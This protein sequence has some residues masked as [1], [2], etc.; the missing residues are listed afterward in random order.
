MTAPS[1]RRVKDCD[2][3]WTG[4]VIGANGDV[5]P[6]CHALQRMGNIGEE[7]LE[8]IWDGPRFR[9]FRTFL[10]SETPLPVCA[11]CF[12]RPW[13]T[14]QASVRSVAR[15]AKSWLARVTGAGRGE[16]RLRCWV[17][18]ETHRTGE[19]I[20][21]NLALEAGPLSDGG[22]LDL[23]LW[24]D[25]PTGE[26]HYLTFVGRFVQHGAAPTA[27]LRGFEPLDIEWLE[28]RVTPPRDLPRGTWQMTSVVTLADRDPADP[29]E[30][31]ATATSSFVED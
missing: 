24:A 17:D 22:R 19:P 21:F 5:A 30:R 31:R 12:V 27:L 13:R 10:L 7:N 2:D 8:A 11:T 14:E 23:Y 16:T 9:T 20:S 4:Y 26:R 6:C 18:R 1:E 15:D 3:P 29:K 25:A 28:L